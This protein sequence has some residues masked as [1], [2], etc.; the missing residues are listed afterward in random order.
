MRKSL[1]PDVFNLNQ[2][3]EKL[4]FLEEEDRRIFNKFGNL[5]IDNVR[6]LENCYGIRLDINMMLRYL[7]N[8]TKDF[9]FKYFYFY[10]TVN[11]FLFVKIKTII[12]E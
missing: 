7:Q 3:K 2:L 11:I 5:Y 1:S 12:I 10:R 6:K 4:L 9:V 8:R